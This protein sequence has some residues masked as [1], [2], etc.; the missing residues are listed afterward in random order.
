[1]DCC[2]APLHA[3]LH[4]CWQLWDSPNL[5]LFLLQETGRSVSC[6]PVSAGW[7]RLIVSTRG[8]VCSAPVCYVWSS[9]QDLSEAAFWEERQQGKRTCACLV[10]YT[11][12]GEQ[13]WLIYL[14]PDLPG[15]PT[16]AEML[17][18]LLKWWGEKKQNVHALWLLTHLVC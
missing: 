18:H 10:P 15:C 13:S 17:T 9:Q 5:S 7:S 1:M 8:R 14:D 11:G 2:T 12:G 16:R 3:F 6:L 4:I